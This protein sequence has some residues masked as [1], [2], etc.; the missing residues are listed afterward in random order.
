VSRIYVADLAAYNNGVLH[1]E[2]IDAEQSTDDI[3]AEIAAMLA[4]SPIPGAEEYAIHDFEGFGSLKIDEYDSVDHV[5][6]LAALYRDHG[7]PFAVW[8]LDNGSNFDR[9]DYDELDDAFL[10]AFVGEYD[11]AADFAYRLYEDTGC[12]CTA[13]GSAEIDRKTANVIESYLDWEAI[14]RDLLMDGYYSCEIDGKLYVF[15]Y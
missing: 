5:A 8:Y 6:V 12:V 14:G 9:V 3:A 13:I 11:D 15:S 7:D 4:K 1:G 2:W 10:S